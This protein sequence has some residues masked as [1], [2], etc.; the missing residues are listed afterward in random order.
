MAPTSPLQALEHE[1][2]SL[3]VGLQERRQQAPPQVKARPSHHREVDVPVGRDALF[4][5][6]AGLDQ[7]L[8]RQQLDELP[9]LRLG[10]TL[11]R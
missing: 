5:H 10:L 3:D 11:G 1:I 4:E 6:E 7:G 9:H 8:Q 2:E